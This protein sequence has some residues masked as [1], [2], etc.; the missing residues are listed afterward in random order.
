M[1]A[2]FLEIIQPIG[3]VD[4]I[5]GE[6]KASQYFENYLYEIVNQI[7]GDTEDTPGDAFD[8]AIYPPELA[9]VTGSVKAIKKRLDDIEE[10]LDFGIINSR[11]ASLSNKISIIEDEQ[12]N[13]SLLS[14]LAQLKRDVDDIKVSI[15]QIESNHGIRRRLSALEDE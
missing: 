3:H 15:P 12:D 4:P 6:I 10:S 14:S 2:S 8:L 7:G 5:T 1:A 11:L 9:S 13:T